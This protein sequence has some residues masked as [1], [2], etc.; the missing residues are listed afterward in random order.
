MSRMKDLAL[1]AMRP[2]HECPKCGKGSKV[3]QSKAGRER[4]YKRRLCSEC[5]EEWSTIE[6]TKEYWD[7]VLKQYKFMN[8]IF[9][10]LHDV[11]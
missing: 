6:V 9:D 10:E 8:K 1:R 2:P 3:T 7:H 5:G 11:G 4:T